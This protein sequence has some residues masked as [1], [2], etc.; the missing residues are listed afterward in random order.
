MT[1]S[2]YRRVSAVTAWLLTLPWLPDK[3]PVAPCC[4]QMDRQ[5]FALVTATLGHLGPSDGE[6]RDMPKEARIRSRV[7]WPTD[8]STIWLTVLVFCRD[9]K[10]GKKKWA[11]NASL[12]IKSDNFS[13]NTPCMCT[14]KPSSVVCWLY[15]KTQEHLKSA[16]SFSFK[17]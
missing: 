17:C 9:L 8:W 4:C 12:N 2:V 3:G 14:V 11:F 7:H 6:D 15:V 16:T 13:E 1:A 10:K 5:L